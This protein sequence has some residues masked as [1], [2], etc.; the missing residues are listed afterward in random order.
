MVYLDYAATA[1]ERPEVTAAMEAAKG[2]CWANPNSLHGPG[3]AAFRA[4]EQARARIAHALKARNASEITFTSGGTESDN[5]ALLGIVE[6]LSNMRPGTAH[7]VVSAIEHHAVLEAADH[8]LALGYEVSHVNSRLDGFVYPEDVAAAMRPETVLVSV[9]AANNE[10]GTVQPIRAIADVVH[11]H[12]AFLHVDGVQM[13]GKL[14]ID[15]EASGADA[16]SFSSHKIG[17][18]RGMGLLYLRRTVPFA[19]QMRGGGQEQGRRS[20]TQNAVGAVGLARAVELAV[21]E[22]PAEA[23]RLAGLRDALLAGLLACDPSVTCAVDMAAT[24]PVDASGASLCGMGVA[25]SAHLPN[26]ACV[27][28]EGKESETML[29]A[30]DAAG[31]AASGGSACSSASLEPSH[32]LSALEIPKVRAF[33]ELRFSL[34]SPTTQDDIERA[35]AAFAEVVK[36]KY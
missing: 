35:I 7:V 16:A 24:G 29:M 20:G 8:L 12:D 5:A 9:M 10:I 15:L 14:P 6:R 3:K 26:I 31:I 36:R 1:P 21:A 27:T 11:A 2:E 4:L 34:G 23:E 22:C 28:V 33:G 17:G 30:L 18:P 13:L 19:S 25:T 32:V